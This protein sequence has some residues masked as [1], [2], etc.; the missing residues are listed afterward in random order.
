MDELNSDNHFYNGMKY[1]SIILLLTFFHLFLA[2]YSTV[3]GYLT[4][5]PKVKGFNP[6]SGTGERK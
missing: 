5:N 4:H 3:V 6:V 1:N 2:F